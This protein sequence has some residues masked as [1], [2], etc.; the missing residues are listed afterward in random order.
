MLAFSLGLMMV[1]VAAAMALFASTAAAQSPCDWSQLWLNTDQSG[2]VERTDC[3]L[4]PFW[5][6]VGDQWRLSLDAGDLITLQAVPG[7]LRDPH[8]IAFDPSN[9]IV[10]ATNDVVDGDRTRWI[11]IRAATA[12]VQQVRYPR[13]RLPPMLSWYAYPAIGFVHL[14]IGAAQDP[15][16]IF[17]E[18]IVGSAPGL[19]D[20]GTLMVPV[21]GWTTALDF[22][23]VP[24][25]R[26]Y[27]RV[28]EWGP[29]GPGEVSEEK[30]IS[31]FSGT[32]PNFRR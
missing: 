13:G 15:K 3:S 8:L 27:V 1:R 31:T 20:V 6:R 5:A 18:L 30:I 21:A 11:T 28:R 23:N 14:D 17:Y 32:S 22:Y 25:G 19:A 9:A 26:Y 7:S 4:Q 12:G 2:A 10:A 24:A 29:E 16:P